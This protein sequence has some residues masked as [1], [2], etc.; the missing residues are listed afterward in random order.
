MSKENK[1]IIIPNSALDRI[2]DL[3]EA[4][5]KDTK[6]EKEKKENKF[7]EERDLVKKE[8]ARVEKVLEG[9][10]PTSEVYYRTARNLYELKNI[11][12]Y[13]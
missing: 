1:G 6:T 8:F 11:L 3:M 5:S 9:L 12:E 4:A 2:F 10:D 13:L 7:K